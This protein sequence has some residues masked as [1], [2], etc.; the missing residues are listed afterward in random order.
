MCWTILHSTPFH[1]CA[2]WIY[3]GWIYSGWIFNGWIYNGWIYNGYKTI[4]SKL[5][6]QKQDKINTYNTY[7][8]SIHKQYINRSI[9]KLNPALIRYTDNSLLKLWKHLKSHKPEKHFSQVNLITINKIQIQSMKTQT[10][11]KWDS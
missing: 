2:Q 6:I 4:T 11:R 10:L 3:I 8:K 5:N 1:N 7:T 9:H